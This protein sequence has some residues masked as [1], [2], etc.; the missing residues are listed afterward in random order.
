[1]QKRGRALELYILIILFYLKIGQCNHSGVG[2]CCLL[3]AFAIFFFPV[4]C[5]GALH[6][7]G[8]IRIL[9]GFL[10]LDFR[11]RTISTSDTRQT[12]TQRETTTM[13]LCEFHLFDV[14]CMIDG[15]RQCSRERHNIVFTALK[16]TNRYS[17]MHRTGSCALVCRGRGCF[18]RSHHVAKGCQCG[19][20]QVATAA[21]SRSVLPCFSAF[22]GFHSPYKVRRLFGHVPQRRMHVS[23]SHCRHTRQ[24]ESLCPELLCFKLQIIM[25]AVVQV[26]VRRST[27]VCVRSIE[28]VIPVL[29]HF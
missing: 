29:Q 4:N 23:T 17:Y 9:R 24:T 18:Q 7:T 25:I 3:C 6:T 13:W 28:E 16:M 15:K 14:S 26:R 2:V 22:F 8:A 10:F 19:S 11:D 1:M 20:R 5:T 12:T 27:A 21:A